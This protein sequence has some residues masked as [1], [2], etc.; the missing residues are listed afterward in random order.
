MEEDDQGRREKEGVH[1]RLQTAKDDALLLM[2]RDNKYM[3]V[4][5]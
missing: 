2:Q 1:K 3:T 4:G 5:T